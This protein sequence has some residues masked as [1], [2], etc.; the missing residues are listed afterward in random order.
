MKCTTSFV[1]VFTVASAAAACLP[2]DAKASCMAFCRAE[3]QSCLQSS[4]SPAQCAAEESA[5]F[6]SCRGGTPNVKHSL[7][8]NVVGAN[9]LPAFRSPPKDVLNLLSNHKPTS[10]S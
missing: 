6:D 2:T 5:C 7:T 8:E 10:N 9:G 3:Y 1:A 4:T